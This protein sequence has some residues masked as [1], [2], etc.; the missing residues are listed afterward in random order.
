MHTTRYSLARDSET[1]LVASPEA[2]RGFT[3]IE[4]LVVI[5]IIAVLIALL[6]PAVQAAREAARRIQCINNLKQIGLA[7]HNYHSANDCFPPGA[8]IVTNAR[9]N[10]SPTQSL[11]PAPAMLAYI[12][13][14]AALQRVE[15]P[16]RYPRR[17]IRR[18]CQLDGEHHAAHAIPLPVGQPAKLD[19][20]QTTYAQWHQRPGQQLLRVSR[21]NPG[22]G[23]DGDRRPAQR[24]IS[25]HRHAISLTSITDG[26]SSTIAFGEWR[27]GTGN[28]SV[29]TPATDLVFS[30][31]FPAGPTPRNTPAMSPPNPTFVQTFPAWLNLCVSEL[32]TKR[33]AKTGILG[34]S[35]SNA[36]PVNSLGNFLVAPNSPTGYCTTNGADSTKAPGNYG[37]SSHHPGGANVLLSDG[38]VR[39]LKDSTS[40]QVV[41]S[42]GSHHQGEIISSDAY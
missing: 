12:G 39:F 32:A 3:L 8:L 30:G 41:W 23:R 11:Q 4:L 27:T 1:R 15:L 38:S 25:V 42:L 7:L 31:V 2:G 37:P 35:W 24:R 28:I 21:L 17:P 9:G 5:A 26:S 29:I 16:L 33:A 13:A 34:Q 36:L 22:M 19:I 20:S 6:L 14:A 10:R 18:P 40:Q